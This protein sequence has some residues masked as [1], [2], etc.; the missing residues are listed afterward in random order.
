MISRIGVQPVISSASAAMGRQSYLV[1]ATVDG[2]QTA[3]PNVVACS[4]DLS[5]AGNMNLIHWDGQDAPFRVYKSV[6]G[7][8]GLIGETDEK[9]MIDD[10]I[11][12]DLTKQPPSA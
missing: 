6:E 2:E 1:T 5:L 11:L 10:N 12:P 9:Q 8:F 4:N 7:V 3:S